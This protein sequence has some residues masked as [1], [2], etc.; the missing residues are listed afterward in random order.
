M[1]GAPDPGDSPFGPVPRGLLPPARSLQWHAW[2]RRTCASIGA[3]PTD[4]PTPTALWRLLHDGSQP[5]RGATWAAALAG[6][7]ASG[8]IAAIQMAREPGPGD[9]A[10]W[11]LRWLTD[12]GTD[13]ARAKRAQLLKLTDRGTVVLLQETHWDAEAAAIWS[14][15][16]LP[17]GAVAHSLSR[18]G[19]QGGPQGGVAVLCPGPKRVVAR[20]ELVPG[21]AVAATIAGPSDEPAVTYVSIYMPPGCQMEVLSAL[22]GAPPPGAAFRRGRRCQH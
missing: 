3:D 7:T 16:V 17:H 11:N 10:T 21:C 1:N 6:A 20:K 12:P 13:K 19:P 5:P 22:E 18:P 15:G 9:A 4:I 2:R 8:L 14:S